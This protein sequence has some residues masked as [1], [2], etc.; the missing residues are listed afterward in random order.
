VKIPSVR[1]E[2]VPALVLP[3]FRLTR[4]REGGEREVEE[5]DGAPRSAAPPLPRAAIPAGGH[6]NFAQSAAPLTASHFP[7][8]RPLQQQLK[9]AVCSSI[10][11][12]RPS[13]R[14]VCS[15]PSTWT[16]LYLPPRWPQLQ[17]GFGRPQ[18]QPDFSLGTWKQVMHVV[19][20]SPL[21]VPSL[22]YFIASI[23]CA[24]GSFAKTEDVT[25]GLCI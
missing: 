18:L 24:C 25:W 1:E 10:E 16:H 21:H 9:H 13:N 22:C 11:A 19:L 6:I 4:E 17:F 20:S 12:W 8:R 15:A 7:T 5:L 3:A 2:I 14:P 23:G